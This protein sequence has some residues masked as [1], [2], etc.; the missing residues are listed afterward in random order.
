MA[1]TEEIMPIYE[2][3]CAACGKR[4]ERLQGL[5]AAPEHDCP[6]CGA[7]SGMRRLVSKAA[8]M[9]TG[10]GWYASGYGDAGKAP[11]ASGATTA[12]P[13]EP[14]ADAP[15]CAGGCACPAPS[16]SPAKDSSGDS[17]LT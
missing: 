5:S 16:P 2:Y 10:G 3:G 7:A 4:E 1:R 8:F 13:V 15:A 6:E 12:T 14:K 11:E 9:F 17:G